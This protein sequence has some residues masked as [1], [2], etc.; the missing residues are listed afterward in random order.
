[1][2]KKGIDIDI[3]KRNFKKQNADKLIDKDA[4]KGP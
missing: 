3:L 1:M 4:I 2:K